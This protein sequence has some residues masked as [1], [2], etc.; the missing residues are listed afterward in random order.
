M[1]M[2][3]VVA[4]RIYI[5]LSPEKIAWSKKNP[6]QPRVF[7]RLPGNWPGLAGRAWP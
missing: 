3:D 7:L 2:R 5:M 6:W 4:P 1:A